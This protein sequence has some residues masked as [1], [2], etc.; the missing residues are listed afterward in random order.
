MR[1]AGSSRSPADLDRTPSRPTPV[2][3]EPTRLGRGGRG[4]DR[5]LIVALVAL[6]GV[7]LAL[8]KPWDGGEPGS[9]PAAGA[10]VASGAPSLPGR[11]PRATASAPPGW[12]GSGAPI[13]IAPSGW[14]KV[15]AAL[16]MHDG[17]GVRALV[18]T[19]NADGGIR[20][21]HATLTERWEPAAPPIDGAL[22]GSLAESSTV[23]EAVV[24]PTSGEGVRALGV[25]A[26]ADRT[27]LEVRAWRL[28]R[29]GLAPRW[30]DV[31][32]VDPNVAGGHLLLLPPCRPDGPAPWWPPG[33]YRLDL[34][35][36]RTVTRLTVVL[37][38]GTTALPDDPFED[39]PG[40]RSM[41]VDPLLADLGGL[42]AGPFVVAGGAAI[43]V[44]PAF[45]P[46]LD[47]AAAWLDAGSGRADPRAVAEVWLPDLNGIGQV[48]PVGARVEW[49]ALERIAP[50]G[51][52]GVDATARVVTDVRGRSSTVVFS[53]P[54]EGAW[55]AGTYALD[56]RWTEGGVRQAGR[57]HIAV[58]PGPP[59]RTGAWTSLAR[60]WARHGGAWGIVTGTAEPLR[61]GPAAAGIRFVPQEPGT[62]RVNP[63]TLGERC[64]GGVLVDARR[65]V[66][67]IAHPVEADVRSVRVERRFVEGRRLLVAVSAAPNV[68]PGLSIVGPSAEA[69]WAAGYYRLVIETADGDASLV[70]CLGEVGRS[71]SSVAPATASAEAYVA[72]QAAS[73]T[74]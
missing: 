1:A 52:S 61:G 16:E 30:L 65:P 40:G 72:A 56:V 49:A 34:L 69:P 64:T 74:K 71:G 18:D 55:P 37:P 45:G 14:D 63:S 25:T 24:M 20:P 35:L 58:L 41:V 70:V 12:T 54:G 5:A 67:A 66:V 6:F 2:E 53:P 29:D 27:P 22:G 68:V 15:A 51:L 36:G 13:S 46:A 11:P 3:F 73:T 23:S 42:P 32:P 19:P 7:G 26:P 9:P 43:P 4:P 48:L 10:P 50:A 60:G 31:R 47:E 21:V 28:P 33:S 59:R 8:V 39:A 57:W 38:D 17:W 44:D 62:A